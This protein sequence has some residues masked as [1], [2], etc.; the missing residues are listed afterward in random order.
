MSLVI[1]YG[2]QTGNAE[3]VAFKV[4]RL[5]I[6]R[7]MTSVQCFAADSTDITQWT[8][9]KCPVLFIVS[10]ANQGEA[11]DTFR[12]TWAMLLQNR[13]DLSEL[14]YA[15]FGLG[16]ST[17]RKF[18]YMGKMLHNRL[19]QLGANP[20][21]T[22]GLGDES[23]PS[24]I[25]EV[26]LPWLWQLW[27]SLDLVPADVEGAENPLEAPFFPLYHVMQGD[28]VPPAQ[29]VVHEDR[30]PRTENVFPVRV[31]NTQQITAE[32]HFQVVRHVELARCDG[33]AFSYDVGDALG[34]Y[35]PNREEQVLAMLELLHLN[36]ETV[37]HVTLDTSHGLH[38]W[39]CPSYVGHSM[40]VYTLLKWYVD[41]DAVT[42]Q[43][44]LWMMSDLV[45]GTDEDSVE[46]R[47]RLRELSD[48]RRVEE[49]LQYSHREKRNV[50]E[51]LQDFRMIHPS[52]ALL[53]T[54]ATPLR[55]RLFS[56]SSSSAFDGCQTAHLTVGQ[57]K[58]NTPLKRPR[59][60]LCSTY[61]CS[62]AIGDSVS[63]F[64]W[65]GTLA[66]PETPSPLLC[67]ATGTGI[68]PIR[69]LLRSCAASP[70]VWG[71]T[72]ISLFFGCRFPTKDYL[73][74]GEWNT[75]K[76]K[77]PLLQV[78]P[79]FSRLTEKKIYVHH[80]L[81]QEAKLVANLLDSTAHKTIIYI[82]GNAKQMPDDTL[83][84]LHQIA[85]EVLCNGSSDEADAVMKH[86]AREGRMQMDTWSA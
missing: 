75:L 5:C 58:W 86:I 10:N 28:D 17:Y 60:G 64:V 25:Y 61:L 59:C 78:F 13:F 20:L 83:N 12:R 34:V 76:E 35:C 55:P 67:V 37:V 84:V 6:K 31:T 77:L 79:A 43:E 32:D 72:P 65:E 68:A 16:D 46:I 85:E 81:G 42:S 51:V 57:L 19:Q 52:L 74:E 70:D 14:S 33:E 22:R 73:Y 11:P 3:A 47:D 40:S 18:N 30:L 8:E 38:K 54:F 82:C 23:D 15:V 44:F 21:L 24:G 62:R 49:Y 56:I 45:E 7:G 66:T 36:V 26:L 53:L 39:T 2:T 48:P 29:D 1:L 41:L 63:C 80:M 4:A 69:A 27:G 9:W 71:Q 50:V